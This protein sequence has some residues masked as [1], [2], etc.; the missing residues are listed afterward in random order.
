MPSAKALAVPC[1]PCPSHAE[2]HARRPGLAAEPASPRPNAVLSHTA[3]AT[4][5]VDTHHAPPPENAPPLRATEPPANVSAFCHTAVAA[6]YSHADMLPDRG[7]AR[8]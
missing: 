4:A 7:T 2:T 3:V 6:P 5:C 1:A 8:H